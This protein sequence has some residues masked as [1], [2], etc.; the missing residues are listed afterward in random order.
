MA[1]HQFDYIFAIAMLFAFLDAWN[2]GAN[3]VANSFA[4]SVSSRSLTYTQAMI[5]AAI[6]EFLGAVLAGSR[7]SDTIR[8]NIIEVDMFNDAPA[9]LMLTM[10]CALFG[11]SIW[12]TIATKVGAP[13]STTHSI[14]GGIIGA[15]IAANGASGVA[16]GWSGFAKIIASWFI[17]PLVAGG[18]ASALFLITKYTVLE[19]KNSLRNAMLVIPV[20][21]ALTAGVLIMVIVWKGA[22]NLKLDNLSQGQILGAIFGGAGAA[23]GLYF[24]FWYPYLYRKLVLED[25]TLKLYH[26]VYGPFL[27]TRGEVP[28][29]PEGIHHKVV[30]DYYEG[31]RNQEEIEAAIDSGAAGIDTNAV[32]AEPTGKQDIESKDAVTTVDTVDGDSAAAPVKLDAINK[33]TI[34]ILL[35]PRNWHR[36]IWLAISHGFTQD[37]IGSQKDKTA[38]SSNIEDMHARAKKYDNK[39]EHL[40]SFLQGVTACTASFAHG[41]NDISNAAGPLSTIYLIWSQNTTGENSPV[42]VW[43][44]C[45]TAGALVIGLWTYGYNIMR[46]LGNRLTLQS[47]ARGFSMELGAAITTVFATQLSLPISTTQCIVGAVVF[48]GLCNGD[49]KAVNW[50]M[51][52]WCYAG[53]IFTLPCAGLIA[54]ITMGIISNAPQLGAVYTME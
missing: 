35:H 28:P 40:Y 25:W 52:A 34:K 39:T 36:L 12:M 48:V 46:N 17:S 41:S 4:T 49:V 43:V 9:G 42:P 7:V 1:L 26:I 53:W 22:P 47:P 13:V 44:L 32:A 21:F 50:R 14:V 8:N 16:W 11:S 33:K 10:A 5:L 19:R 54:G 24:I 37:V 30:T 45:Y 18:F 29:I 51:V 23:A 20:Y 38:L 15:G 6:C 3:D 31:N 27:L 2:I